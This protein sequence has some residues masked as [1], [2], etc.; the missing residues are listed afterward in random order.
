MAFKVE[1]AL[2]LIEVTL[3]LSW[4]EGGLNKTA[5]YATTVVGSGVLTNITTVAP[6]TVPGGFP[7][8]VGKHLFFDVMGTCAIGTILLVDFKVLDRG[9]RQLY[10]APTTSAEVRGTSLA[11]F[12]ISTD[13]R[14][15]GIVGSSSRRQFWAA[16]LGLIS[17]EDFPRSTPEEDAARLEQVRRCEEEARNYQVLGPGGG[18][19]RYLGCILQ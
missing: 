2:G 5:I 14:R 13:V 3:G 10:A 18:L 12:T 4:D 16:M 7:G 9:G 17:P 11:S 6:V 15:G 19:G 8:L 1:A